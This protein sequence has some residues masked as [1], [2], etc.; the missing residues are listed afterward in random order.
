DIIAM[1]TAP[2]T[3]PIFFNLTKSILMGTW[4]KIFTKETSIGKKIYYSIIWISAI[5]GLISLLAGSVG[6]FGIGLFSE[7]RTTE[8]NLHFTFSIVVFAGL[9]FGSLFSG[10]AI[11]LKKTI[12]PRILGIYMM[13]APFTAALLFIFSQPPLTKQYMEWWMLFSILFWMV[14][15]ALLMYKK[16]MS[17]KY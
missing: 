11:L 13:I 4:D 14:P 6:L 3:M 2:F 17:E 1:V 12:V 8:L 15:G 9:V 5:L 10:F 16:L 7:D